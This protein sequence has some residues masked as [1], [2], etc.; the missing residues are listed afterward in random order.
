[1]LFQQHQS[2]VEKEVIIAHD[3]IIFAVCNTETVFQNSFSEELNLNTVNKTFCY[4]DLREL[5]GSFQDVFFQF[6]AEIV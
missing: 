2:L 4:Y 5:F 6:R 3:P 1:M